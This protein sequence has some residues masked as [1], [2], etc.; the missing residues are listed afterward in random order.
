M[1]PGS[2]HHRGTEDTEKGK[3]QKDGEKEKVKLCFERARLQPRRK[4]LIL[5][6]CHPERAPPTPPQ[7]GGEK[8]RE[9][10]D[11]GFAFG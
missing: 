10:R 2:F 11:L 8:E 3:R 4:D 1:V 9:S 5:W 6:N 7:R